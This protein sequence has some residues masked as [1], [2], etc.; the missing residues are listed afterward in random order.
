MLA[1]KLK[2]GWEEDEA[3]DWI[4][5]WPTVEGCLVTGAASKQHKNE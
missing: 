1:A 5:V 2:L 3:G 4:M